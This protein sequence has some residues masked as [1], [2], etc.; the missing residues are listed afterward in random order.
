MLPPAQRKL[1]LSRTEHLGLDHVLKSSSDDDD[2][3]R[4]VRIQSNSFASNLPNQLNLSKWRNELSASQKRLRLEKA[5]SKSISP[6]AELL[7]RKKFFMSDSHASILDAV[8]LG[9]YGLIF[10]VKVPDEWAATVIQHKYPEL[11]NWLKNTTAEV[12]KKSHLDS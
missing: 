2:G 9:Y 3:E 8:V 1:A 5:I 7:G 6:L 10:N 12:F 4:Q 11:A